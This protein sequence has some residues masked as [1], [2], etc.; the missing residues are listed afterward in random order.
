LGRETSS[1]EG[2]GLGLI[3]ARSLVSAM[4]GSLSVASTAGVGTQVVIDLPVAMDRPEADVALRLLY[5]EDNRINAILFQEAIRLRD[6]IGAGL[7]A[8]PTCRAPPA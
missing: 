1:I 6:R 8:A 3:I 5:V 7:A 4:G 2:S